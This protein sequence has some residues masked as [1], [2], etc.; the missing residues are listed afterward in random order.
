MFMKTIIKLVLTGLAVMI[1]AYII[2][3]VD[4]DGFF[5][6]VVVG[7]I[8]ALVNLIVKPVIT[9][10]TLPINVLTLGLFTFVV[11]AL[12]ILLVAYIVPGFTVAGWLAAVLFS[13]VLSLV[14]GFLEA[15]TK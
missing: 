12:M 13:V 3:G 5:V 15:F 6:A 9:F 4:V 11:N 7:V 10:L 2:P 14:D 8:L 1:S